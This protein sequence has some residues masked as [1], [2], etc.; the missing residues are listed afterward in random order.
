M[1]GLANPRKDFRFM[2][3]FDGLN[4]FLVQEITPPSVEFGEIEHG[5]P[6]NIPTAK[7]PGK[8]KVG[9]LVVKKLMTAEVA[10]TW[11]DDWMASAV[12]GVKRDFRKVGF[13]K[14]LA[15]DAVR[16]VQTWFL[17][18]VWPKKIEY[19]DLNAA[20]Q[21]NIIQTV[22]FSTQFFTDVNSADFAAL[23]AGSAAAAGGAAFTLGR[24]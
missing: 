5:T 14:H 8:M 9:D 19:N 12:A 22:T 24:N 13:L 11:A 18:E 4:A 20:G 2:L 6:G 1:S 10:D 21:N 7:T 17:G 15:P 16:V 23:F 3:E